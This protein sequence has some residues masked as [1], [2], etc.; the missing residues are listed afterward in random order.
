MSE[1]QGYARCIDLKCEAYDKDRPIT[2][3]ETTVRRMGSDDTPFKNMVENETTYTHTK[4]DSE[5][6]CPTCGKACALL[7]RERIAVPVVRGF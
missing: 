6:A 2:L 5:M 7:P 4:D 3:V 1:I